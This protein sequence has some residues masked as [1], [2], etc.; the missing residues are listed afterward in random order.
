MSRGENERIGLQRF[1]GAAVRGADR[2]QHPAGKTDVREL[3]AEAH[4]AA[5]S[6]DHFPQS[7][8]GVRQTVG[9]DVRLCLPENFVGSAGGDEIVQHL[10]AAP[11][12][13]AGVQLAVGNAPAP[14]SPNWM[15]DSVSSVRVR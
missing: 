15:L 3:C 8:Y 13:R 7:L 14:P 5:V 11:V 1:L 12:V 6:E 9:A 2:A 10:T 4:L